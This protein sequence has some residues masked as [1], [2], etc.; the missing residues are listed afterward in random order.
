MCALII[1]NRYLLRFFLED[2]KIR[3]MTVNTMCYFELITRD[4]LLDPN[5]GYITDGKLRIFC[6][7]QLCFVFC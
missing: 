4:E 6:E 7:V 2:E 5:K 1:F 3:K